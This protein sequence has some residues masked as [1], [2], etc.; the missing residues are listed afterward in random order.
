MVSAGTRT[1]PHVWTRL[2]PIAPPRKN[3]HFLVFPGLCNT[4][5]KCFHSPVLDI[6]SSAS[7]A[8]SKRTLESLFGLAFS[9]YFVGLRKKP[10]AHSQNMYGFIIFKRLQVALAENNN[11]LQRTASLFCTTESASLVS[12]KFAKIAKCPRAKLSRIHF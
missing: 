12:M 8:S 7:F 1:R 3:T 10:L 4:M 6:F 5:H 11:F 2:L 9:S